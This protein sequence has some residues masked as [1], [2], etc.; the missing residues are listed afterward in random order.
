MRLVLVAVGRDRR[1]PASELAELYQKRCPWRIDV[2]DIAPRNE[3]DTA[4]RIALEAQKIRRALPDDAAL[5]VL[6]ERGDNLSSQELAKKVQA[7]QMKGRQVIAFVIGGADGLERSLV[8]SA[9]VRLAFGRATW[10]HR[11][12]RAMVMEQLYRVSTILSG[13]PYHRE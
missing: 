8:E 2:V 3:G 12:V 7:F 13:H 1:G 10:P 9:D 11:F 5:V 4:K 6:D